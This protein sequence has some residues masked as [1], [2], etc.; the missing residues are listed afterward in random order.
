MSKYVFGIDVGGTTVKCGLFTA[1]GEVLDKWE[2]PTDTADNGCRILKDI[3][4]TI[5][6]K[7][8]EK[9]IDKTAVS[10]IGIAVPGPVL[11]NGDV[12]FA[13]NLH[14]G[15]TKVGQIMEDY[16]GI[17]AVTGNDA[18]VA[19]LG[20][21]WRGGG[22]GTDDMVM[23][24]L[25]TGVGGGVII[26]GKMVS[27]V[28]GAGGEIGHMCI[29]PADPETCNCGNNGCLEQK[30]SA[31]GIVRLAR[32]A[33]A[34][35]KEDTLLVAETVTSKDVF[36]AYAKG[37]VVAARIV[38]KMADY[39]GRAMAAIA[40]TIDPEKFVI[41]GGVSKAGQPLIDVIEKAYASYCFPACKETEIVLAELGNDA[42]IFG[43]AR[44]V[45]DSV[46]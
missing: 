25:G 28:H 46:K 5:L 6:A 1:E 20:E 42:G 2:I 24:T 18:N 43:S 33:L 27:G 15:Y 13:V 41:G 3:A 32:E 14:W 19:A 10:G 44:M 39:L 7:C 12:P 35:A 36:D 23:I 37:D 26:N 30:T 34:Q 9:A 31:T 16:T 4:D 11:K 8:E 22:R 38:E 21:M 17:P 40:A 45:L 29:D